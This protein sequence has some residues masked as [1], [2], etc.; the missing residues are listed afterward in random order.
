MC[1]RE[2]KPFNALYVS[3]STYLGNTNSSLLPK[4]PDSSYY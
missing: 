4:N 3:F 1:N 2:D